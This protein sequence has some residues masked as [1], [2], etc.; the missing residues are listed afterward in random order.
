M[1][2]YLW[3]IRKL[4]DNTKGISITLKNINF[5]LHSI[6]NKLRKLTEVLSDFITQENVEGDNAKD[7]H[8][9]D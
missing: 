6:D 5:A 8:A 1:D 4:D 2:P 9:L 3:Y 7:D